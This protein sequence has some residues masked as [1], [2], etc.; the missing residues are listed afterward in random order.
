MQCFLYPGQNDYD[1]FLGKK[2]R[3]KYIKRLLMKPMDSKKR[4]YKLTF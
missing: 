2:M 4:Y 1:L 3:W